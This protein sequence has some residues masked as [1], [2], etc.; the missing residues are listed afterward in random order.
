MCARIL[1]ADDDPGLLRFL[2]FVLRDAGHDVTTVS[3]GWE[4]L[5]RLESNFYDLLV[6][7]L[8]MPGFDGL[9]VLARVRI[10]PR[11]PKILVTSGRLDATDLIGADATFM[12]GSELAM[13]MEVV[14]RLLDPMAEKALV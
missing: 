3:S 10:M 6:L 11:R 2:S 13:F 12:K 14:D 1:V 5:R 4:A 8:S 9:Q 7:D